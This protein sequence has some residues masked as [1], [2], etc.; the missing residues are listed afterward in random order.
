MKCIKL[1]Q[2]SSVLLILFGL[3]GSNT[4]FSEEAPR[5]GRE[6]AAKYFQKRTPQQVESKREQGPDDHYLALHYGAFM[7]SQS[8]EWAGS[9]RTNNVGD[10]SAGLTYRLSE[11]HNSMDLGIR[12]DFSQYKVNSDHPLKMSMMPIVT[13]PD[14]SSKFPLY[15]GFGAGLGV[16]FKQIDG[17]SPL[18]VDYQLLLGAR[19]FNVYENA[20]FFLESGLKNSF[21]L[22]TTGQFNGTF[23][24]GGSVFTF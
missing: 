8:W 14:A 10:Y 21:F 24:S 17:K 9:G 5:V 19:F 22:S 20:G 16:F 15:F 6:A 3:A 7:D 1:K 11:W 12:V 18:A 2:I 13:F 4:A 23:L